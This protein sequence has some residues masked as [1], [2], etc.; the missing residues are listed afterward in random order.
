M[1]LLIQ[2]EIRYNIIILS[3]ILVKDG[4]VWWFNMVV[5]Y[6]QG[7]LGALQL[8][9]HSLIPETVLTCNIYMHG[10]GSLVMVLYACIPA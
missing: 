10:I 1:W 6:V 8:Y 3:F 2:K 5:Q 7:D 9:M 4:L